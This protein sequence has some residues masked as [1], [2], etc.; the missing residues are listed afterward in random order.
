LN[1]RIPTKLRVYIDLLFFRILGHW[2]QKRIWSR[3]TTEQVTASLPNF[4]Y[5]HR[6]FLANLILTLSAQISTNHARILELGCGAGANLSQI[7]KRFS[8]PIIGIDISEQS[9][10]IGNNMSERNYP[11]IVRLVHDF[12]SLKIF[13]SDMFSI[14]FSDAAL[15]TL[16]GRSFSKLLREADRVTSGFL[17]FLEL[18]SVGKS[19]TS[20]SRD[21]FLRDYGKSCEQLG[22]SQISIPL[23]PNLRAGGRWPTIGTI[24][25]ASRLTSS[26][27]LTN[28]LNDFL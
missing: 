17:V 3:R 24:T 18:Q 10:S 21:G 7:G 4:D 13:S 27:E 25:V 6:E 11:N 12:N 14:T 16:G 1:H 23:P 28:I 15:Y 26:S 5:P 2:Q 22:M 8:G 19:G 20:F 9:I